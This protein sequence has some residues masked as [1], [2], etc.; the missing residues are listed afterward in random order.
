MVVTGP[1]HPVAGHGYREEG[2]MDDEPV[3]LDELSWMGDPPADT[4]IAELARCGALGTVNDVLRGFQHNGQDVPENLPPRLR[5]FLE[6]ARRAPVWADERRLVRVH[7]FFQDDGIHL[8]AV[9][10][11]GSMALAYASQQGAKLMHCTHRLRYPERRVAETAQFVFDLMQPMPFAPHSRFVI[12]VVKVRLIHAT[13]RHHLRESGMWD[14]AVHGVPISQEQLLTMWLILTVQAVE[15]LER[16]RI[17]VT[18]QEAEDYLHAWRVAG[19]FL[20]IREDAMPATLVEGRELFETLLRRHAGPSPEGAEL[21]KGLLDHY[22]DV[23]PGK[24]FDGIVPAYLRFLI[25]DKHADWLDVPRSRWMGVVRRLP[26]VL[27]LLEQI[28]DR[29]KLGERILDRIGQLLVSLELRM[30]T[31]GRRVHLELP[32]QLSGAHDSSARSGLR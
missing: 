20:G 3:A 6:Q 28:E 14:E 4:L 16:M 15:F 9:L 17:S 2:T 31:H 23:V 8:G 19:V 25:G 22:A 29:S 30:L 7:E 24:M 26:V 13:I 27:G 18:V 21:T 5:A 1:S 10:A 11:I 32:T 12:S